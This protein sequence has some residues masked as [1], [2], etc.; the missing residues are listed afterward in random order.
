MS[1]TTLTRQK[2]KR[3]Y[4]DHVQVDVVPGTEHRQKRP[5]SNRS[6]SQQH[7]ESIPIP[8]S[9]A[10]Y[11]VQDN[12]QP[13]LSP[14]SMSQTSLDYLMTDADSEDPM[15]FEHDQESNESSWDSSL[16]EFM[17]SRDSFN[18]VRP[19]D[20]LYFSDTIPYDLT[21][22]PPF[23]FQPRSPPL[24]PPH[25]LELRFGTV[26]RRYNRL[27]KLVDN[28]QRWHGPTVFAFWT[29]EDIALAKSAQVPALAKALHEDRPSIPPRILATKFEVVLLMA[30]LL[31]HLIERY[32][33]DLGYR[34]FAFYRS[35][36]REAP[37]DF[38]GDFPMS[39]RQG[40]Y[41]LERTRTE[42]GDYPPFFAAGA[43]RADEES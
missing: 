10:L 7:S 15:R 23:L 17:S 4:D 12:T 1:E 30:P 21:E 16:G 41:E 31:S 34:Y 2:R 6:H 25:I 18:S 38:Q 8:N 14:S 24:L 42:T 13:S 36:P 37:S 40:R 32:H 11:H 28:Y 9:K 29:D 39:S 5:T 19:P 22:I 20:P 3:S 26:L 43:Q 33:N 35:D 27:T